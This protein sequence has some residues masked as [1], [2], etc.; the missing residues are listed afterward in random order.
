MTPDELA[1]E[2]RNIF[3][4]CAQKHLPRKRN[5]NKPWITTETLGAIAT[6][7][8]LKQEHGN[9]SSDYK[10]ANSTVKSFIKRGKRLHQEQKLNQIETLVFSNKHKEMYSQINALTR[11]FRPRLNVIKDKNGNALTDQEKIGERWAEYCCEM[12]DSSEIIPP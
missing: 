6:R 7:K 5:H 12:Y 4:E 8:I 2:I 9:T 1:Q 3:S 10:E 11:E